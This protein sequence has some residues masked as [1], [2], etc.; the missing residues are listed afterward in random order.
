M[1]GRRLLALASC[2]G[3]LA[4][5]WVLGAERLK[6]VFAEARMSAGTGRDA[7]GTPVGVARLSHRQV[8]HPWAPES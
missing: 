6:L 4:P 1:K 5:A 3:V 8:P 7:G 2:V